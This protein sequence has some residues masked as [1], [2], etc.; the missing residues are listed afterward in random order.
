MKVVKKEFLK[1]SI[2]STVSDRESF[3]HKETNTIGG[4]C[5]QHNCVLWTN[6]TYLQQPADLAD[7]KHLK[8]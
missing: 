3:I 2:G 7:L 1:Q 5:T 4:H 6:V 8:S